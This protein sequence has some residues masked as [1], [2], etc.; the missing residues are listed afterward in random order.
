VV[1]WR[2]CPVMSPT[3]A[4]RIAARIASNNAR[5]DRSAALLRRDSPTATLQVQRVIREAGQADRRLF[6]DAEELIGWLDESL[7][8][9]EGRRLRE[10]LDECA[11]S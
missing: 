9:I 7:T 4:D 8:D 2:R 6:F 3:A 11:D 5:T 1:D 10:F